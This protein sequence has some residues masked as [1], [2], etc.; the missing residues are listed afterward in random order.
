MILYL[1]CNILWWST[2]IRFQWIWQNN[3]GEHASG[4]RKCLVHD[5]WT[6]VTNKLKHVLVTWRYSK[7]VVLHT[8]ERYEWRLGGT[9]CNFRSILLLKGMPCWI[10][11]TIPIK[12]IG[13]LL[14]FYEGL[15][16]AV[17]YFIATTIEEC[18]FLPMIYE[19]AVLDALR[20]NTKICFASMEYEKSH[21]ILK[22][23]FL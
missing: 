13:I 15:T 5:I 11:C 17:N 21:A 10:N 3:P 6:L 4:Q 22:L 2:E 7:E 20:K 1:L 18:I 19:L 23:R 9:Q 8:L 14:T 12:Q 16:I